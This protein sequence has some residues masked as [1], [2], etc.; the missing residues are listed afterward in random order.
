MWL[1][2]WVAISW[3]KK[4]GDVPIK[5]G[6]E[7]DHEVRETSPSSD[8]TRGNRDAL[9]ATKAKRGREQKIKKEVINDGNS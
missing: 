3:N 7:N 4:E 1:I 8:A 9:L 5:K 6:R 2:L